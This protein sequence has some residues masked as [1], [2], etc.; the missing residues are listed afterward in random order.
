MATTLEDLGTFLQ[1]A[2]T[3]TLATDLFLGLMPDTPDFCTVL[4][5]N[6]GD[7]SIV[8]MNRTAGKPTVER[9]SVMV[10]CRGAKDDYNTPRTEAESI[11][12]VINDVVDTT[13]S[14]TRYLAIEA[15][16]PPY[17]VG[18]DDNGRELVGF[19]LD[20]WKEANA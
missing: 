19:N 16:Q 1:T 3:G 7:D 2:G 10:L 18:R 14:S 8:V 6:P 9:P 5:E 11:Y 4:L 17:G 13:L 15:R 20:I 12:A